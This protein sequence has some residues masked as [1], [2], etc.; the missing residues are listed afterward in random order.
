MC[1]ERDPQHP[2]HAG[3]S[4][5]AAKKLKVRRLVAC[6]SLSQLVP[7][8]PLWPCLGPWAST[9]G[10]LGLAIETTIISAALL[11]SGWRDL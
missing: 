7:A 5:K 8:C 1:E 3:A 2:Y 10:C 9:P 4:N 11:G 6:P